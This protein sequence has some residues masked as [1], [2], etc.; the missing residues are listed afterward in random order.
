MNSQLIS[1]E[2]GT[3]SPARERDVTALEWLAVSVPTEASAVT[4]TGVE[5]ATSRP[6]KRGESTPTSSRRTVGV[7]V[8]RVDCDSFTVDVFY[9]RINT[10]QSQTG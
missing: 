10:R 4:T 9:A 6:G 2:S 3:T 8:S 1:G 5:E 7:L